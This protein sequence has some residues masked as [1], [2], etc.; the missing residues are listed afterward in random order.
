MRK[1]VILSLFLVTLLM[2]QAV[3]IPAVIPLIVGAVGGGIGGGI[4]G[5]WLGHKVY[6][7][8]ADKKIEQLKQQLRGA[9]LKI[10]SDLEVATIDHW[11]KSK[12][13]IF[14][15]GDHIHHGRLR[16]WA[17]AKYTMLRAL[18]EGYGVNAA[19]AKA[20]TAVYRYYLNV[21]KNIINEANDTAEYFNY[22]LTE[23]IRTYNNMSDASGMDKVV[24][25]A[26]YQYYN[27][28]TKKYFGGSTEWCEYGKC[29]G[30]SYS[31]TCWKG[32]PPFKVVVK[33]VNVLGNTFQVKELRTNSSLSSAHSDGFCDKIAFKDY[34]GNI[35]V[36]YDFTKY[37][38]TLNKINQEY[39]N[40]IAN[41]NA[42][43]DALNANKNKINITDLIDPYVLAEFLD[44]DLNNTGYYG[45][46]AAEL[47]LLGLN[48]TGLNKTVTIN[49]NGVNYT[50]ILFT[51][52]TGTLEVGKNYTT[53]DNLWFLV[54]TDEDGR[55]VLLPLSGTIKIVKLRDWQGNAINK[56][57]LTNYVSHSGDIQ[58]IYEELEKIRQLWQ[59]YLEMKTTVGGGG[60]SGNSWA[61]SINDF[62]NGLD[63]QVKALIVGG[64]ILAGL[65]LIGRAFGRGGVSVIRM[66]K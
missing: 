37:I 47:A 39:S 13:I 7:E 33:K 66:G 49:I 19:A 54:T 50:G 11:D 15:M 21:T 14:E 44:K 32:N 52:W 3:A 29:V 35:H 6:A 23:Y 17:L 61:N 36:V 30:N 62:W 65:V 41:I 5:Y 1:A 42:Y 38:D 28:N 9:Q 64:G 22:T 8:N 18:K 45:F 2:G 56:T 10:L 51:D 27:F 25:L 46:A 4:I 20:R 60:S 43:A 63:W 26:K 34:R 16:A 31:H 55:A 48:T 58:K 57:I 12:I 59:D 40:I 24:A 53:D